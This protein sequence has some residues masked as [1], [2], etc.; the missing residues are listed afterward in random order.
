MNSF[1]SGPWLACTIW[2]KSVEPAVM[3]TV[4]MASI[5]AGSA[6]A[7]M[8]ISRLLPMPPKALPGSSPPSARKNRPSASKPTTAST[9]PNKLNGACAVTIGTISPASSAVMNTT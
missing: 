8:V 1:Q 2:L 4:K 5:I 7:A 6:M 9:P 3:A